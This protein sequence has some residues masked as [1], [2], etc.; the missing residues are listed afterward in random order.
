MLIKWMILKSF[1]C[2]EILDVTS[3]YQSLGLSELGKHSCD[4][5]LK[6]RRI[7]KREIKMVFKFGKRRT[8]RYDQP[9]P[10]SNPKIPYMIFVYLS[11]IAQHAR[12]R[13]GIF[14]NS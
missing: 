12:V 8:R 13:L 1:N 9:E 3:W 6:S 5:S 7:L 14:R 4:S 2:F 10:V 11:L